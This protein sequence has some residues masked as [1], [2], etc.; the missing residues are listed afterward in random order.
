[1]ASFHDASDSPDSILWTTIQFSSEKYR[2]FIL[3]VNA[4][5]FDSNPEVQSPHGDFAKQELMQPT[6]V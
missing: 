5:D 4:V 2:N 1:M 3:Y 6:P